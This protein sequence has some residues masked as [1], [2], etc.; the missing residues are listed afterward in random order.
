MRPL[1][2]PK[3]TPALALSKARTGIEGFDEITHGGLPRGRTTLVGGGPGSGKTIMALQS[4]VHAA[5]F[6]NEPGIFVAFEESSARIMANA[7]KFGWDLPALQK[8]KLFF[9]DVQPSPDLVVA[10]T[11][12]LGGMLAALEAK[13]RE[14]GARRI[15]FDAL[16]VLLSLLRDPVAEQPFMQSIDLPL[17]A[18]GLPA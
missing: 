7:E 16:D 5:R 4:L 9:L 14:I 11:F 17:Q 1:M 18:L 12:D 10:G 6:E 3:K 2:K 15:V 8:K 13:A